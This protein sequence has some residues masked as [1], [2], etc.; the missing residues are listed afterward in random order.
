MLYAVERRLESSGRRT[1]VEEEVEAESDLG[2]KINDGEDADLAAGRE[3]LQLLRFN[4]KRSECGSSNA[5]RI[6]KFLN[7]AV[8]A[9][10]DSELRETLTS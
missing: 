1:I 5:S 2:H 3:L 7:V 10:P 9:L 6:F 8:S 4:G